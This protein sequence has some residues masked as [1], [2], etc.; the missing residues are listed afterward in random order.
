M[1]TLLLSFY[2]HFLLGA[3]SPAAADWNQWR[4]PNRDGISGDDTPLAASWPEGGPVQLWKSE[5]IPSD[6][7][8]GHGSCVVAGGKVYMGLVWH[9]DEPTETRELD[10]LVLSKLGYR[11]TDFSP[12]LKAAAEEARLNLN[13]RLRGSALDEWANK[14]VEENLNEKQQM[15]LGSWM[16][17]RFRKGEL[18]FSFDDLDV[19]ASKKGYIFQSPKEF[20]DWVDAQEF[21]P[22]VRA[23]VL[24]TVPPTRMVA[25]DAVVCLD[26]ETGE[27][28]WKVEFPAE[29]TSRSAS[30]TP[31]VAD[32]RVYAPLSQSVYCLDAETGELIWKS[33][34]PAKAPASCPAV[35]DGKVVMLAGSLV[36]YG[37]ESGEKLWEQKAVS[38]QTSSPV[39]WETGG[40]SLVVCNSK[41]ALHGVDS[42]TGEIAWETEGGGDAT[43]VV[44]GDYLVNFSKTEGVGLTVYRMEPG[45]K[46]VKKLWNHDWKARRHHASP[47][48]Y[49]RHVYL[50]G[51]GKHQCFDLETGKIKWEELRKSDISSPSLADGKIFVLE[52]GGSLTM[53]KAAPGAHEELGQAKL[54]LMKCPTPAIANGKVFL[55]LADGLACF[56]LRDSG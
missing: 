51:G 19:L 12:E 49:E 6:H 20:Q 25:H 40:R 48:I 53:L 47:L 33:P 56:D 5:P 21:S 27:T 29:K 39:V 15:S 2:G 1:K 45:G 31:C 30:S 13:P 34:L 52:G 50:L 22:E 24:K 38:G 35:F 9:R 43:A 54:K 16:V 17:S 11:G 7:Y 28:L 32:G 41:K 46:G 18:A 42:R 10:T 37:T 36:A 44:S 14:W 23:H 8:G 55:R 4:G 26:E 3:L